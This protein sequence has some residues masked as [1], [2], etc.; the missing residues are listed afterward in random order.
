[1]RIV[2]VEIERL[3]LTLR[4][5]YTI[6]YETI[7]SAENVLL[8]LITD[9]HHVGLG[10][11]APDEGVTGES[12]DACLAAMTDV[13]A[14]GL[15]GEDALRR[16]LHLGRLDPHLHDHP[17]SRSAVDMALFDLLGKAGQL[18]VWRIL[19]GHREAMPTSVTLFITEVP[20]AVQRARALVEQG[21]IAL[22]VKGG[23][24]VEQDI[25][26]VRAIRAAVGPQI[27]LRFDANQG[28]TIAQATH[29]VHETRAAGVSMLEQPVPAD[30]L[31]A[32]RELTGALTVPVM[33]DES[34]LSLADALL[35]AR[36]DAMDMINLKLAKVGGID[37]A[38]LING[39]ARAAGMEVMVGCGD[40]A[41][42]SIAAGLAFALSRR[43]VEYVDLD[44]HLDFID[45]PTGGCVFVERGVLRP[46]EAPGWG[47]ED[48]W[49]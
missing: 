9:T 41:E 40:E 31:H 49:G 3:P 7:S 18:P 4:E 17:A 19:G 46:S 8:R 14:P 2:R 28:Y 25:T 24:D 21:F 23:L 43:N 39:V 47:L 12:F 16:L 22:K 45:D 15:T 20:E 48:V 10:I 44:G 38:L 27:E 42:L 36:G 11:A 26:R 34:I 6:A 33:A 30:A 1:M 13:V 37:A 5:P 35:F 29:F 32:M